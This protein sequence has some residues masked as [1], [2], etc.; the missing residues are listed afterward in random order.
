MQQPGILQPAEPDSLSIGHRR[1][2]EQ[3]VCLDPGPPRGDAGDSLL[4]TLVYG[5]VRRDYEWRVWFCV[6]REGELSYTSRPADAHGWA[7]T[8]RAMQP[9][10]VL[11]ATAAAATTA[12][13]E[14]LAWR[15]CG[16][17]RGV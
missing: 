2:T 6:P 4:S 8:A 7:R 17:I 11:R 5:K 13:A 12:A 15:P 16:A 14:T 1:F 9:R 3:S 10:T